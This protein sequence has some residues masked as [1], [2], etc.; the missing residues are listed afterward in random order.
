MAMDAAIKTTQQ[1]NMM[2]IFKAIKDVEPVVGVMA[3]D[4]FDSAHGFYD[5]A[6][7]HIGHDTSGN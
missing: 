5:Y 4:S 7:K 6:A 3:M 1:K 2:A